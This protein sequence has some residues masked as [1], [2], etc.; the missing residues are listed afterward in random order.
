MPARAGAVQ[1]V[2]SQ[3]LPAL[4]ETVPVTEYVPAEE[5]VPEPV[6]EP[7]SW[8]QIIPSEGE[9]DVMYAYI[10]QEDEEILPPT[11]PV[12]YYI[13]T[14]AALYIPDALPIP[15][16]YLSLPFYI[17]ENSAL[18]A[19]FWQQRPDLCVETVIWKVNASVHVPFYS[20]IRVNY[21]PNPLFITPTYRLPYGFSPAILV[22]VNHDD[23]PLR[24]TPEAV[25]AFHRLRGAARA[26]GFD[27]AVTSAYRT[28]A[29][30]SQLWINGGRRD[31]RVA[32]PYHS[33][34]QTGR[35]LDLWGPGGGLLDANGPSPTGRWVADNVHEHGFVVRYRAET[36]HITGYIHEPWHITYVSEPISIYMLENGILSL[37]EFVGRNPGA[38]L[39]AT[40]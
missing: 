29:R 40:A 2:Q 19:A 35:A 17:R 26:A 5:P 6:I 18:Y 22:P 24:A 14:P 39:P 25:A 33:E 27:L 13:S 8:I 30:Q 10:P 36:T 23:C 3:V 11:Q 31:G 37:E 38:S 20:Q 7:V 9:F 28:A 15:E 1:A 4:V 12:S 21:Q 34:H 32:R 16:A